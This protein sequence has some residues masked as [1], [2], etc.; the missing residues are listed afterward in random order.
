MSDEVF[1]E[2]DE[3]RIQTNDG[4]VSNYSLKELLDAENK[5]KRLEALFERNIALQVF[6]DE[7]WFVLQNLAE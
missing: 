4:M 7:V 2:Q 6:K 1:D 3:I 5:L